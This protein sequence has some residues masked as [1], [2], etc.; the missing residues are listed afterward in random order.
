MT[1][2]V[3]PENRKQV[4]RPSKYKPEYCEMLIKHM[5]EGLS[6][7]SFAG[8]IGVTKQIIYDWCDRHPEFLD[9]KSLGWAKCLLFYEKIGRQ[10][11]VGKLAGFNLGTWI[12]NMKNR[13]QWVD[14]VETKI[15]GTG[16]IQINYSL[17]DGN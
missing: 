11:M 16:T 15:E 14:R 9:A 1:K 7:E 13:F 6:F 2:K 17:V 3:K 4:G 5:E 8:L 10:G 12:F